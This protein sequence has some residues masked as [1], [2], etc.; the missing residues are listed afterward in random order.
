MKYYDSMNSHIHFLKIAE[1]I[2]QYFH[3]DALYRG[4]IVIYS[5]FYMLHIQVKQVKVIRNIKEIL[6][7]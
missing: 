6:T 1:I 5:T 7:C 3:I 4:V 2:V